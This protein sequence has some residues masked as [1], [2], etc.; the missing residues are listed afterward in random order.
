MVFCG[1]FLLMILVVIRINRINWEVLYLVK[2]I[3]KIYKNHNVFI[4]DYKMQT[5]EQIIFSR[6][7]T[8]VIEYQAQS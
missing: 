6:Q 3:I 2:L 5:L 1:N 4:S 8:F 7:F